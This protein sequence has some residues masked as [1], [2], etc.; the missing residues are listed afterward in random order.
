MESILIN[1]P[2]VDGNKRTAFASC[3]VFLRINGAHINVEP[4]VLYGL[5]IGWLQLPHSERWI[6][7]EESLRKIVITE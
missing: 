4:D 7:M 2:F 5:I 1:H 6:K 3:D